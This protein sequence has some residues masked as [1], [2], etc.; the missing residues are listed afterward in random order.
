MTRSALWLLVAVAA[1]PAIAYLTYR[2]AR[3]LGFLDPPRD[4]QHEYRRSIVLS[5]YC[6][7]LF[8]PIFL[9]GYDR[10]WPR[11]WVLFGIVN[12]LA[13]LTFGFFGVWSAVRLWRLRHPELSEPP[14]ADAP[15]DENV[16]ELPALRASEGVLEALAPTAPAK[17]EPAEPDREELL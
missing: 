2:L 9:F 15:S 11:V 4:Q 13:L 7:L 6:F 12:G 8:L 14:I 10:G 3:E 16:V 17:A 5:I 1:S